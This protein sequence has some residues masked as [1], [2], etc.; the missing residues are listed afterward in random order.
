MVSNVF[1]GTLFKIVI[2]TSYIIYQVSSLL[3]QESYMLNKSCYLLNQ[4]LYPEYKISNALY[5]SL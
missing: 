1:F 4:I 2:D 3:Y 5:D